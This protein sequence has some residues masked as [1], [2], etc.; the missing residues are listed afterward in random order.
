MVRDEEFSTRSPDDRVSSVAIVNKHAKTVLGDVESDFNAH[1]TVTD[2]VQS[3]VRYGESDAR[4]ADA[5]FSDRENEDCDVGFGLSP[6]GDNSCSVGDRGENVKY[7]VRDVDDK[8][9]GGTIDSYRRVVV[10]SANH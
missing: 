7:N 6:L 9:R 10:I 2:H 5:T 4:F 8:K 1:A 3:I